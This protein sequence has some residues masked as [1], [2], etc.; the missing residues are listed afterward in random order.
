MSSKWRRFEVLLPIQFNDGRPVPLEWL[1]EANLE[2]VE[3]FG[4]AS[5][6]TLPIK[7]QWR[8]EEA[9][10]HDDLVK[11]VVDI[12]ETAKNRKWMRAF[13]QAWKTRL[14]QL[15]L[16]MVSFPIDVE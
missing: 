15:E 2:I 16:W 3:R 13:K 14:Q 9:V 4:A 1:G 7:G 12:P 6:E 11:I 10:Y 5:Y 8:W